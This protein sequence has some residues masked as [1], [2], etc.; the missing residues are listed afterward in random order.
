MNEF[1]SL[2]PPLQ[3]GRAQYK[4]VQGALRAPMNEFVLLALAL[5]N[6]RVLLTLGEQYKACSWA[7]ALNKKADRTIL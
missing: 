3:G 2:D 6:P 7:S 5:A 1:A 4:P